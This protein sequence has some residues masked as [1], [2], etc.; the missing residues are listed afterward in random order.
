MLQL[1]NLTKV[2][3]AAHRSGWPYCID[4]IKQLET[5]DAPVLFDDFIERTFIYKGYE[6]GVLHDR[7]WVGIMHHPP[8]IPNW[9]IQNLRIE[10]LNR[11]N[12][13][14][15][16]LPNL[17]L[18]ITL[19]P[20]LAVWCRQQWPHIPVEV[21]RHPTGIPLLKWS[22]ERFKRNPHK[23][24]VQ[25]GWF[26]RNTFGIYQAEVDWLQKARVRT[27]TWQMDTAH[28]VCE[29]VYTSNNLGR[30]VSGSVE[31]IE[32]LDDIHYDILLSENVVF[33]E[34]I[35]S[36]AN[37]TVVEC[38]ARNTPIVV[39]RLRGPEYYLGID[40]PLFYDHFSE[41]PKVLTEERVLAAH[42]YLRRLNKWWIRGTT[43][44]E[45]LASVL[46]KHIPECRHIDAAADSQLTA[47]I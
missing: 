16:S 14:K 24:L 36:V 11:S 13:W 22:P 30:T 10:D 40:Y 31:I 7:P 37:N 4:Y 25:V 17:R 42:Q 21:L 34:F 38:I 41:I 5:A 35:N 32:K 1:V 29:N 44:R 12:H 2:G 3:K 15:Q 18:L 47:T 9:Y 43:F 26:L 23:K 6:N 28:E 27:R 45:H 33:V 46:I 19:A 8:K 20:N 39:N